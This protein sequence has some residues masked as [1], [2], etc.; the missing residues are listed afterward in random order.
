MNLTFILPRFNHT[1]L[2]IFM[3]LMLSSSYA[4]TN[5]FHH[6]DSLFNES[7][8]FDLEKADSYLRKQRKY[9]S[10]RTEKIDFWLNSMMLNYKRNQFEAALKDGKTAE[11]YL[12][13][14]DDR[15]AG[16]YLKI[17]SLIK[18]KQ[19]DYHGAN[20]LLKQGLKEGDIEGTI[21]RTHLNNLIINNYLSLEEY[22]SALVV[23]RTV[24]IELNGENTLKDRESTGYKNLYQTNL[25]CLGN[26]FYFQS[27][28]DS[29]LYYYQEAYRFDSSDPVWATNCLLG[30]ADVLTLKGDY[31]KAE[32]HYVEILKSLENQPKGVSLAHAYFNCASNFKE[33]KKS[34]QALT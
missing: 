21:V 25:L 24:L 18:W 31:E 26:I 3:M 29:S 8:S 28:H 9:Y 30:I 10:T 4:Q 17:Q 22:D 7:L 27:A 6:Y 16:T 32:K 2:S 19:G 5:K 14:S 34:D 1:L 20:Q 23:A 15:R 12:R 11:K 33:Q 13:K